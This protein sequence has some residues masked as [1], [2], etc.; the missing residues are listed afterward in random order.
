MKHP[1]AVLNVVSR[2]PTPFVLVTREEHHCSAHR[3]LKNFG[4]RLEN[5]IV[6]F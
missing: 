1:A 2:A 4:V 3:N 5:E 6:L